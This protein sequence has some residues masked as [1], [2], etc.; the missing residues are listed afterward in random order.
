MENK[1]WNYTNKMNAESGREKKKAEN[2]WKIMD[3]WHLLAWPEYTHDYNV[4]DNWGFSE[5]SI[6]IECFFLPISNIKDSKPQ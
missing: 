5:Q 3:N 4:L 6:V 1:Y 2:K